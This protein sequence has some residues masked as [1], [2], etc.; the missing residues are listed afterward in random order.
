MILGYFP[1]ILGYFTMILGY[2]PICL[3]FISHM[4]GVKP[5][6]PL[7]PIPTMGAVAYPVSESPRSDLQKMQSYLSG[8]AR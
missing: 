8:K 4:Y 3:G 5:L 7:T 2:F 6:Y 1:M